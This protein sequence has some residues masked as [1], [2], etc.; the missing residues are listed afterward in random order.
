MAQSAPFFQLTDQTGDRLPRAVEIIGN[1]LLGNAD[2]TGLQ[3]RGFFFEIVEQS[4]VKSLKN[5]TFQCL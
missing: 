4:L 2:L 3:G 1:L 5:N